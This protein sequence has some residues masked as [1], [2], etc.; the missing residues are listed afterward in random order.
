MHFKNN[1]NTIHKA[2][3]FGKNRDLLYHYDNFKEKCCTSDLNN[4][5][6]LSQTFL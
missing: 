3:T 1:L 5:Q 4:D 6:F 2:F